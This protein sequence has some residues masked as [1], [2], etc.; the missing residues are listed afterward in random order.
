MAL[1]VMW[2]K[3]IGSGNDVLDY[4]LSRT[5]TCPV[6]QSNKYLIPIEVQMHR[7]TGRPNP[8]PKLRMSARQGGEAN[9]SYQTSFEEWHDIEFGLKWRMDKELRD[10]AFSLFNV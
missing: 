9:A 1:N 8:V 3:T 7:L 10:T 5:D 6:V 2:Y 4:Q